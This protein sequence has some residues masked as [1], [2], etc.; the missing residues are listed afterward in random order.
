MKRMAFVLPLSILLAAAL[1]A[2]SNTV[3]AEHVLRWSSAGDVLTFDSHAAS[4][5][6]SQNVSSEIYETLVRRGTD[7]T[8]VPTLAESWQVRDPLH[9][10]FKLRRGVTFHDGTPFTADDVVFS[11]QRSQHHNAS[12]RALTVLLGHPVKVDTYTVDFALA[13]PNPVLLE[14]LLSAAI[15][16]KAW[17]EQHNV[18]RPQA[19]ADHE[20]TYAVRHANG[21]GPY[22]LKSYEPA[23]RT[24][25]VR[26]PHYW[27]A[28]DGN[29]TEADY[30]PIAAAATRIAALV[31]GELDF[32]LDPPPQDLARLRAVPDL[33]VVEGAEWR[34]IHLGFDQYRDE[35]L[36]S[37]VKGKNP[38][39]DRRVRQAFYQAIDVEALRTKIMRGGAVPT[40]SIVFAFGAAA[41]DTE[42]RLPY[43]TAS[44]IK[45]L[46]EAGYP[47]G[48]EVRLDC[49]NNRYIN[50]EQICVAASA[51]LAQIGIRAPVYATPMAQYSP[52][53]DQH[54]VSFFLVGIGGSARDPQ[55]S[56]TLVAHSE[57]EA[58]GDG[59]FNVGRFKDEEVD[60]LIDAVKTEMDSVKRDAMINAAV[61]KLAEGVYLI[62]LHRQKLPWAMRR[63]VDVVHTPY[64]RLVL[65]W[66]RVE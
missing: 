31:S 54:D 40:G 14:H 33:K 27:G 38:F 57:S 34:V 62:P 37:N 21:T 47:N 48:F 42:Q 49:P 36:Y 17:C 13:A 4:D 1:A 26:N 12:N 16:S 3:A 65:E 18:Q 58:S 24:V 6:F 29:V 20:E 50:D 52:R 35:L 56:L 44:A 30:R 59:R 53:L 23:V 60:R 51:M 8:L 63:G 28:I 5:S 10:R 46:A 2:N 19:Y 15:L 45:L 7:T 39:K 66:T 55:N 9:W 61:R 43:D 64:N 32:V 25:L 41:P 22:M 11:V